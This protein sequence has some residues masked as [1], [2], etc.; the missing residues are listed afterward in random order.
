V[1][2]QLAEGGT[3]ISLSAVERA[4]RRGRRADAADA[5]C[6][7]AYDASG[8]P[9]SGCALVAVGGYGR[10]ELAPYSD[11]DVVLVHEPEVG[12]S[13]AGERIWYPVWDSGVR[14]D[15]SV[16]TAPQMLE[17]AD[18]DLRV[19]LGLLDL[20]HLAGD[21]NLTLRL[22][23]DVLAHWRR[24]ARE[25][26]PELRKLVRGRHERVGELAHL[27]VPDLKEAEG[28][29]RDAT[30]LHGLVATW[31]V[32]VPHVDLER[33]RRALLD[34]RDVLHEVAGR[35]TDRIAPEM[36]SDLAT[37]LQVADEGAAQ[38]QVRE[39]G[40]RITHLSRLTWR[41]VDAVVT[42]PTSTRAVRRPD[43]EPLG[44]GIG[45]SGAEVV[46]TRDARP[47]ADPTL[48]LRAAAAAGERDVE[49]APAMAARLVAEGVGLPDPWPAAARQALVRLLAAGPGLLPVWETLEETGALAT[50]L[51]E[52]ERIRLLP[53]ASQIHRFT[54]DRHVVES[55][56]EA[57][58]LIRSV[59]R[60]D[61]LLVSALLHDI[62][63]GGLTEHSI[64]GEPLARTIACRM[65][66]DE[67]A[68]DLVGVLV[69]RHLLLV[70]TAT[71]RDPEDPATATY[72]AGLVGSPEALSLLLALTEADARATAVQA[73]SPWRAGLVRT[74]AA[75]TAE[76]L[77]E[78]GVSTKSPL[79]VKV[80]PDVR[81]GGV[82]VTVTATS[83]G[84]RVTVLAPDR[85]GLLADAAALFALQRVPVRSARAWS[86]GDVGVSVWEVAEEYLD[87]KVLRQRYDAIVAGR[88]DPTARLTKSV[89][90][91]AEGD[92]QGMA[93]SVVVRPDA[94]A[95]ATVLEVRTADRPGVVHRVCA[96]LARLDLTVRSAHVDTLGPQAV[97]VFYVQESSAGALGDTRAAAAAHA[98]REALSGT[99]SPWRPPASSRTS[100]KS[101]RRGRP[102]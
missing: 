3:S 52:W 24:T 88:I 101:D 6:L 55:C 36:W 48:L 73:W 67:A 35:A 34:L 99:T 71:S 37:R 58:L 40:R 74:V 65:G 84:A 53:H 61:V 33:S 11:L 78:P 45:L 42:A 54:V 63:K 20:R 62:G 72:L 79:A 2:G 80:P 94:S 22:R 89:T 95:H 56:R 75:R 23:S 77:G 87:E 100:G 47:A 85:V 18:A 41:R 30:V 93:P 16:R 92:A 60:P 21:P 82:C 13:G 98:V 43:V 32:D 69:R 25:R 102:G 81:R 31:L 29:L 27:S 5:L 12:L 91:D 51:P 97:D 1:P 26:L 66:F 76:V 10:R 86:Q 50:F 38:R 46:L 59:A 83:D 17:R 39:L 96:A 9:A 8:A 4:E 57:S 90:R 70:E 68:V 7:T 14:L 49:L 15:H 19:A 28:G 44:A 64:A